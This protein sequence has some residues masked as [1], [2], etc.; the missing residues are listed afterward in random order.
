[1]D[2]V[3]SVTFGDDFAF[4]VHED[5][6]IWGW[7]LNNYGQLG[8]GERTNYD[9]SPEQ[10]SFESPSVPVSGLNLNLSTLQLNPGNSKSLIAA[11]S[12]VNA[13]NQNILWSVS[14]S[15]IVS[16][17][18]GTVSALAPGEADVTAA[19]E[20][21]GFTAVCHVKVMKPYQIAYMTQIQDI[22][23][24]SDY[25][26][27]GEAS[28]T[29]GQSKRLETIRI[30]VNPELGS[31]D[32]QYKTHVQ[33]IG[34]MDY[35]G[36]DQQSGTVGQCKRLEA[37]QIKLTGELADKYDVYYCVHA[38]NFGWMGWAKND[39]Q[40]G[41]AGYAY[42][43]EGIKIQL[44]EKDGAAPAAFEGQSEDAFSDKNT[45]P[46]VSYRTHVQDFG[47]QSYVENGAVSGT[48]GQA[49]R[50]EGINIDLKNMP[51]D[52]GIEYRTHIENIG[53]ETAYKANGTMSGTSGQSLRLEAI[54]IRLTGELADHYDVYYQ[55]HAE[56]YGW[57]AMAK[58]D[59]QSGTAGY[60]YR[61]EGIRVL[62]VKKGDPAPAGVAGT[63]AKA[64]Y[65][66]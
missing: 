53:W 42:R 25:K 64:F 1:M 2:N 40:A 49:K 44:V 9:S 37:I 31:G 24:E 14:D 60:A 61:L 19:S 17:N 56:N 59:E 7:G 36:S 18:N 3:D 4:A 21:G 11:I 48:V 65:K 8:H 20:D 38:Q 22:G 32:I 43:L 50:L 55:V 29:V 62:L 26:L 47:W 6:S 15:S 54:Q 5:H 52:G 28:G 58:N 30:K 41:T 63:Q 45:L 34:W 13:S 39:E 12:P 27:D 10:L 46:A 51:Y 16:V 23:W 35:V 57:L 66:K 33:D